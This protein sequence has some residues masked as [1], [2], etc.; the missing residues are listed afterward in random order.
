MHQ[1]IFLCIDTV[2]SYKFIHPN[3]M[4]SHTSSTVTKT[5][6]LY[7]VQHSLC[8]SELLF[9]NLKIAHYERF[10]LRCAKSVAL[11]SEMST[12]GTRHKLGVSN[13]KSAA[14]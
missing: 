5:R 6:H 8:C 14:S 10:K 12:S 7:R 13:F 4:L 2:A 3:A 11:I 1:I 9:W